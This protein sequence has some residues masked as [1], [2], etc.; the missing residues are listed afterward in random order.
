MILKRTTPARKPPGVGVTN[1]TS[2]H[3]HHY[4][5][6]FNLYQSPGARPNPVNPAHVLLADDPLTGPASKTTPLGTTTFLVVRD[7]K[8]RSQAKDPQVRQD[9]LRS[10]KNLLPDH[11]RLQFC[12][13]FPTK[14]NLPGHKYAANVDRVALLNVCRCNNP[15]LCPHCGPI[16]AEIKSNLVHDDLVVWEWKGYTACSAAMTLQ[17]R[18]KEKLVEVDQRYSEAFKKMLDSK[19]G[20]AFKAKWCIAGHQSNPDLTYTHANGWHRHGNN[21]FYLKRL[22]LSQTEEQ[23]FK[24]ELTDLWCT[25][26]EKVGG[27]ADREH[28]VKVRFGNIFDIADYIASKAVG[29]G[30]SGKT[31]KTT[32]KPADKWGLPEEITKSY[33]KN[34]GEG[35]SPTQL[36]LG[37]MWGDD[38]RFSRGEAAHLFREYASVFS[39]GGKRGEG[40]KFLYT[41]PGLRGELEALKT[42]YKARLDVLHAGVDKPEWSERLT[43]FSRP[44]WSELVKQEAVFWFKDEARIAGMDV[45]KVKEFLDDCDITQVWFPTLD[46]NP[47]DWWLAW[48]FKVD[49]SQVWA[50][51]ELNQAMADWNQ[52][53]VKWPG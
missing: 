29:C 44:A 23:E 51:R 30:G 52:V 27:F 1:V 3:N 4:T 36:L 28:G 9:L 26:V 46:H 21:I 22:L 47:P 16:V 12:Q 13:A 17:H 42:K 18:K 38:P 43:W 40:K 24:R 2:N 41:S 19:A 10:A 20:R 11:H 5:N 31:D 53:E 45:A 32:T 6:V 7:V 8:A 50:I 14:D 33:L 15:W 35:A 49:E 37:Y 48:K 25:W 34:R 39:P